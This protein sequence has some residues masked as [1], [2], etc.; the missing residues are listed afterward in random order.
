MT[1]D[2]L[3][4][5][6]RYLI[7]RIHMNQCLWITAISVPLLNECSC[8]TWHPPRMLLSTF[9]ARTQPLTEVTARGS[10]NRHVSAT[11]PSA[12]AA[13]VAPTAVSLPAVA[14]VSPAVTVAVFPALVGAA[15]VRRPTRP[16]TRGSLLGRRGRSPVP[17]IAAEGRGG[18]DDRP[19][20][21]WRPGKHLLIQN[22]TLFHYE[23]LHFQS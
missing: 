7:V 9:A 21:L 8:P 6:F 18:G 23:P 10:L 3:Y 1:L 20:R 15:G 5:D 12:A 22:W 2:I 16:V 4:K 11:L 13:V 17:S 14:A 19:A